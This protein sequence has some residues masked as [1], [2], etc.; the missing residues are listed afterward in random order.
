LE[1]LCS[2]CDETAE[3][4]LEVLGKLKV[5]GNKTP[6]ESMRQA[7]KSIKG[8]A[9]V[10]EICGRLKRFQEVLEL[11]ILVD[12]RYVEELAVRTNELTSYLQA[13]A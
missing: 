8:K 9:V 13:K 5:Q 4:L 7:I 12:L 10:Q 3:D 2:S 1:Q 11:T 6:W